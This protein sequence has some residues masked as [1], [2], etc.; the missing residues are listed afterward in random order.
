MPKIDFGYVRVSTPPKKLDLQI[1][2][3]L[4]VDFVRNNIFSDVV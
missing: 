2:A 1:N 3:L 4:K